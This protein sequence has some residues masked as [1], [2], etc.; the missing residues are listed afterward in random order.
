MDTPETNDHV[1]Q[2]VNRS[3]DWNYLVG[4]NTSWVNG[5]PAANQDQVF[6]QAMA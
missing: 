3:F 2:T 1:R 4:V 5:H 6:P